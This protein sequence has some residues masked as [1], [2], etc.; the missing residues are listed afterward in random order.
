RVGSAPGRFWLSHSMTS[1]DLASTSSLPTIWPSRSYTITTV[2]DSSPTGS[3]CEPPESATSA[4]TCVLPLVERE[5]CPSQKEYSISSGTVPGTLA[6]FATWRVERL[7]AV[8]TRST[9]TS[10][11]TAA[12]TSAVRPNSIA[13]ATNAVTQIA[14]RKALRTSRLRTRRLVSACRDRLL[15]GR[16]PVDVGRRALRGDLDRFRVDVGRRVLI[17]R[18]LVVVPLVVR[19]L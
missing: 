15:L 7:R 19:P 2:R 14:T 11:A 6:L 1:A 18:P 10:T 3:S 4:S 16:R 12:I 13:T 8:A 17:L 9:K 5:A